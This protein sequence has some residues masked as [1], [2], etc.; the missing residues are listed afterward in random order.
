MS[1]LHLDRRQFLKSCG[2]ATLVGATGKSFAAF[3]SSASA[4]TDT[5]VVVFLRG[6]MDALS[7]V[8]PGQNHPDRAAYE[9]NRVSTRIPYSGTGAGL[10]LGSTGWQLHPRATALR[11]LYTQNHLGIVVGAGQM[12]PQPVVRSHFEAQTNLEAGMG[13]G[14]SRGIGWLTRHLLSA[15]LPDNVAVPAVSMGSI[16]ASSLLGSTE[17]I[18]MNS[19]SSFRLDQGTW[20]WN[21][22]DNGSVA[23]L[24][25]VVQV[26]PSLWQ[27]S[28]LPIASAGL[29]TLDSLALFRSIDFSTWSPGNTAGYKPAGGAVY[30]SGYAT[31][32]Q[33]IA[34]LIKR[35]VGLRIATV[36]VGGWDTHNGQG[37]PTNSYDYFGIQAQA[38]SDA[39]NAFYTDLAS[40]PAGNYMRNVTLITVS[41]FG[42][43]VLENESGGTDHGYG[44]IMMALGAAV[45]G[46]HVYGNF[47]GLGEDQLFEGADVNVTTDYRRVLSEAL[48]RRM[49]NPNIYYAFPG[50]SGYTPI[51]IF[52]GN[53][54]PPTDYDKIFGNGFE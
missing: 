50:Y 41:E 1:F 36:D 31:Q 38:L 35:D 22:S 24:N 28:T 32:L 49:G 45:N 11:T 29:D 2:A 16:T 51:G 21:S 3:D 26:L 40:D 37:N 52:Q 27:S 18:T 23:G 44:T 25:G 8:S 5:L 30:A 43:R 46:G 47:P 10:P 20:A 54:L 13:G 7:L 34:Q 17:T 12:Q 42:R 48:I 19:G 9:L 4:T 6:A 53:D 14:G 39:L 15:G 33:N